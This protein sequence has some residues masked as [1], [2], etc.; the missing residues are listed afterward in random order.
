[1]KEIKS[2]L[3]PRGKTIKNG[4]LYI[5]MNAWKT[6]EKETHFTLIY[7]VKI[8]ISNFKKKSCVKDETST[9]LKF[10]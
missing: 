7:E 10:I 4:I 3:S 8:K 2:K 1:M 6:G 5:L 9:T